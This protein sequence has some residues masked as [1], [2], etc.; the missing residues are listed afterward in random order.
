[1]S[2]QKIILA[3]TLLNSVPEQVLK[4]QL[5]QIR[6]DLIESVTSIPGAFSPQSVSDRIDV[7]DARDKIVIPGFINAH[8]H[9]SRKE[10]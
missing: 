1:M 2:S 4:D 8:C 6:G 7:I 3:G 5:I 10:K 9:Q